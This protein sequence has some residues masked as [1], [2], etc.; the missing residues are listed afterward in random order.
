MSLN[1]VFTAIALI[2]LSMLAGYF[3]RGKITSQYIPNDSETQQLDSLQAVADSLNQLASR[4]LEDVYYY[5]GLLQS[6]D[7]RLDH[8]R[9]NEP[10]LSDFTF[11]TEDSAATIVSEQLNQFRT[12][13]A[14]RYTR[15]SLYWAA[16]RT[17]L[18]DSIR[19]AV[20]RRERSAD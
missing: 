14:R 17:Q 4:T 10:V 5:E 20:D 3:L 9:S 2:C 18:R 12:H 8:I 1:K 13:L 15:D 6:N 19:S 7:A 16:R 11:S